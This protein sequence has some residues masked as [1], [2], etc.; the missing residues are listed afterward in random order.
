[1]RALTLVGGT[2]S[3]DRVDS[4]ARAREGGALVAKF[5]RAIADLAYD[6]QHVRAGVHDTAKHF[7][8]LAR[9]LDEHRGHRLFTDVE[10]L[11]RAI[12]STSIPDFSRLPLRHTHGDLKISNVLFDA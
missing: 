12:L 9:A 10:P 1:W 8:T 5:H 3:V 11:A 6:Y 4:P 2:V 7:A